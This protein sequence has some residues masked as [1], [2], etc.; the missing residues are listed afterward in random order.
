MPAGSTVGSVGGKSARRRCG[1][2]IVVL[3]LL[4]T[5]L[6]SCSVDPDS[7]RRLDGWH[8]VA[9]P[10]GMVPSVLLT[11]DATMTVGGY[12]RVGTH[13]E[14]ALAG[15]TLDGPS[16][17]GADVGFAPVPLTPVTPY[18]K[19]AD[20]VSM[21]GD[22]GSVVA[23]GAAHGGAHANFR[24]TIWSG[25]TAG[26]VD[27]PQT[28]ETFGGWEAGTLL[29]VATDTRGPLIVGT[30]QGSAGQDGAVWRADGERWVRR[31]VEAMVTSADRQVAP[32]TVSQLPDRSVV[33]NGSV[34][35]LTDGVR[36]SAATWRDVN[37]NWTLSLLPDPGGRSEAWS[38]ACD[39]GCWTVGS[40]DGA[41]AAWS[42]GGR[43]ALPVVAVDDAD[44]A[45]V[46]AAQDRVV[47]A[48][49]SFGAGR[50]LIGSGD[51]W[52]TYTAPD[53]IPR[54]VALVGTQLALITGTDEERALWVRDLVGVL[55]P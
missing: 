50:I 14:P 48:A 19:V 2:A 37:G 42:D 9:L 40:R 31:P 25:T 39:E 28:F 33:V 18:G 29:G 11:T 27:R 26:V 45:R 51:R 41:V 32:R 53:G 20:L 12:R 35:A 47:I 7:P 36:Q 5:A 24:W 30:W 1:S 54:S 49:S 21:T 23:L 44:T 6:G 4:A 8:R 55:G 43:V 22:A 38:T 15:R 52:R 3:T 46:A 13:R 17:D 10:G 16:S 34:I